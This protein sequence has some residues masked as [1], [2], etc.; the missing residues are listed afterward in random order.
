MVAAALL[1]AL[2]PASFATCP[3]GKNACADGIKCIWDDYCKETTHIP[4]AFC[5][6]PTPFLNPT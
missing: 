6:P 4:I 2:L 5:V 1:I 3:A